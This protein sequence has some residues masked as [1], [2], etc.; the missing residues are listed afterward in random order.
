MCEVFEISRQGFYAWRKRPPSRRQKQNEKLL[1][2]IKTIHEESRQTYGSPRIHRALRT[3]DY[4]V[5]RN[6][7]AR[8]MRENSIRAVQKRRSRRTTNSNHAFPV[9][10]NLVN[11]E[12]AAAQPNQV[13]LADITYVDTRDGWLYLAAVLDVHSRKIVGWS[14]DST[15]SRRLCMDALEMAVLTR[16]PSEGLIHHSDRGSQYASGDYQELL[17][18][19]QMIC[20]MSRKGDCWDNAPMESFFGTLKT[21]SLHRYIFET[22]NAARREIFDYI[23]VF[24]N[25]KRSHSSL[26]YMSPAA[27]E[28]E[29]A[30]VA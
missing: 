3:K 17:E 16:K 22:K 1:K 13:W 21:E 24:Y 15:M 12:F 25:R 26:N 7:V 28:N 19:H 20:S 2:E 30:Q 4:L 11:R 23:E 6:R 27:F 10:P 9:A 14:M 8:I 29:L 5:G 18:K